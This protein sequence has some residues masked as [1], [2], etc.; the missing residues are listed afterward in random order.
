[1]DIMSKLGKLIFDTN[2]Y[3]VI[4]IGEDKQSGELKGLLR[5]NNSYSYAITDTKGSLEEYK[6]FKLAY[7]KFKTIANIA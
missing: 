3:C 1:M 6:D 7:D 4:L 5:S 2:E